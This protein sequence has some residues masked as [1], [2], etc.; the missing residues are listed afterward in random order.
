MDENAADSSSE[1]LSSDDN[2]SDSED[3]ESEEVCIRNSVTCHIP[4]ST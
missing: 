2:S 3:K 1:L 4:I